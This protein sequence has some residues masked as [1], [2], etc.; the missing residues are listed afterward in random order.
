MFPAASPALLR[1][2]TAVPAWSQVLLVTA[3]GAALYFWCLDRQEQKAFDVL[4]AQAQA[5]APAVVCPSEEDVLNIM[6]AV[7]AHLR[8]APAGSTHPFSSIN[9]RL[10]LTSS[11]E[12]LSNPFGRCASYS[13]VLAKALMTAGYSVRK[14]GL[15]K[16]STKAI[17]HV[18]E[19][20][21]NRSWAVLDAIYNLSFRT[22][23]GRLASA[24]EVSRDWEFFRHQVPP[25]YKADFDYR[26]FYYTNWDRLP[27]IGWVVRSQPAL[28]SWLHSHGIS[29]RFW[30]FNTYRWEA[31]LCFVLGLVS[32]LLPRCFARSR[33]VSGPQ[34]AIDTVPGGSTKRLPLPPRSG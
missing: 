8:N 23:Q 9:S 20:R 34:I 1:P 22:P 11:Y 18:I 3:L 15:A 24:A 14:V 16:G 5:A 7:H 13:H 10:H 2:R 17:H 4:V 28:E 12:Q 27:L 21:L 25:G 32:G 31:A 30:V 26:S 33:P 6:S 19:V 29:L